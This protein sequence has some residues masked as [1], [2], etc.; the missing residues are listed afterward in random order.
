VF[1]WNQP[2][3]CGLAL[4]HKT[5]TGEFAMPD[6]LIIFLSVYGFFGVIIAIYSFQSEVPK[7]L[8]EE[9]SARKNAGKGRMCIADYI[10]LFVLFVIGFIILAVIGPAYVVHW[11]MFVKKK[12]NE[13][14]YVLPV[15]QIEERF[16]FEPRSFTLPTDSLR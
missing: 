8:A 7:L 5:F 10:A 2:S 13:N 15:D 4:A 9:K 16:P 14:A 3:K 6:W 12:G 1:L 11:K